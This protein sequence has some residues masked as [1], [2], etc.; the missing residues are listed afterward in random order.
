MQIKKK[1]NSYKLCQYIEQG[2]PYLACIKKSD[3]EKTTVLNY[4][5]KELSISNNRIEFLPGRIPNQFAHNNQII[6]Y[7]KGLTIESNNLKKHVN[8]ENLWEEFRKNKNDIK[9]E[10]I[11]KSI[12]KSTNIANYLGVKWALFDDKYF[13]KK[14]KIGYKT[15][16]GDSV[17]EIK[18]LVEAERKKNEDISNWVKKIKNKEQLDSDCIKILE[19]TA[20]LGSKYELSNIADKIL[21]QVIGDFKIHSNKKI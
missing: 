18:E 11:Q 4:L 7:L 9:L 19:K 3:K 1:N 16:K 8:I 20:A 21:E 12:F 6:A 5:N 10:Q 14:T 13:F 17:E 2:K 15:R